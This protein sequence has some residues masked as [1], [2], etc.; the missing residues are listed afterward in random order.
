[1]DNIM[2]VT[3]ILNGK[4]KQLAL[5]PGSTV[6]AAL[7]EAG[8]RLSDKQTLTMQ[9]KGVNT[10]LGAETTTSLIEDCTINI[11]D[12]DNPYFVAPRAETPATKS[13]AKKKVVQTVKES[14]LVSILG[15]GPIKQLALEPGTTVRDALLMCDLVIGKDTSAIIDKVAVDLDSPLLDDCSIEVKETKEVLG[16]PATDAAETVPRRKVAARRESV[17]SG[18]PER[19]MV[20]INMDNVQVE[21]HKG[22]TVEEAFELILR[23]FLIKRGNINAHKRDLIA[24]E[25]IKDTLE[26]SSLIQID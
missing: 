18:T 12:D 20:R 3:V 10:E 16:V 1:M 8:V 7:Q 2:F 21:L 11:K 25:S 15:V 23:S 19:I 24:L 26:E 22:A 13:K 6:S 4:I 14:I 17:P 5:E 9:I